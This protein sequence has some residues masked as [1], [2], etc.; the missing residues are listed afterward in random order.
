MIILDTN[1]IS[2]PATKRPNARVLQ[3]LDAQVIE[4][5]Y[6]TAVTVGELRYGIAAMPAGRRHDEFAEWLEN[7]TLPAFAGRILPYDLTATAEYA[8]LMAHARAAGQ[9]IAAADGMIAASAAATGFTV[10]IRDRSPFEA[11]GVATINPWQ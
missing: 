8:R 1:V 9:A 7:H 5:L 10:A 4:T 11:A 3:W 6:L 2:E